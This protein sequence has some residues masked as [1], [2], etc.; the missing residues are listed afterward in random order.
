MIKKILIGVG[1][2]AI[3]LGV[4]RVGQNYPLSSPVEVIKEKVDTL[5]IRDTLVSYKPIS[6]VKTRTERIFLPADTIRVHDTLMV[7][8]DRD[9]IQ[10]RD[11]LC[12]VYASGIQVG[13]DS[14]KHFTQSQV[15]TREETIP[16]I[17]KTHWGVGVS[18]G[19]GASLRGDRVSLNPYIGI[20][21]S[22]NILSW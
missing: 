17:K 5:V 19:Y 1:V 9:Q 3:L 15:I 8:L 14:V 2:I 18:A 10:W 11:S 4:F 7:L 13:V 21:I 22:Y 12:E 20:G 6:V 16:Q